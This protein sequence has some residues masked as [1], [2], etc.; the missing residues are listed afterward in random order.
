MASENK[1]VSIVIANYNCKKY[2]DMC[3]MSLAAQT[4]MNHEVII[5]DNLSE[6]DSVEYIERNYPDV[7][8]IK[9]HENMGFGAASNVGAKYAIDRGTDFILFLNFDTKADRDML[10][11]LLEYADA[12]TVVTP[13]I[14][15]DVDRTR[16][17]YA[18]G[19]LDL[20]TL[21]NE[22]TIFDG[23][24]IREA[25]EVSFISGCC[26]MVAPEILSRI[27][28]FDEDYFLY[29]EDVE[30]CVRLA[31]NNIKML[32][33]PDTALY[34]VEGGSQA[35]IGEMYSAMYYWVRNRL[36]LAEKHENFLKCSP[37][38]ILR[39][40]LEERRYF[41]YNEQYV[42]DSSVN[43]EKK[44]IGDFLQ[45]KVGKCEALCVENGKNYIMVSGKQDSWSSVGADAFL[46]IANYSDANV[47]CYLSFQVIGELGKTDIKVLCGENE[48]YSGCVPNCRYRFLISLRERERAKLRIE[49]TD[50]S[51]M[52]YPKLWRISLSQSAAEPV[53]P[54]RIAVYGTGILSQ[55][56]WD[57]LAA[58]QQNVLNNIVCYKQHEIEQYEI[59]YFVET[60]P[61]KETFHGLPV[62]S[63]GEIDFDEF[64]YLIIA[65]KNADEILQYLGEINKINNV[66]PKRIWK[67]IDFISMLS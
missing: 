47:M 16:S 9:L 3:L 8:L 57:I 10:E 64:E 14:Y 55:R 51:Q 34:H 67:G 37:M 52:F 35:R 45:G 50:S 30:L 1:K 33:V 20:T 60:A 13:W 26:M 44:A 29:W 48:L 63:A 24:A 53:G 43:Y 7:T 41:K 6:D 11:V 19:R 2:V 38:S 49:P 40:I 46:Y 15:N 39:I 62:I 32:Y 25:Q 58:Y 18:G 4:H 36:M 31:Q 59:V 23:Q 28:F 12:C 61:S 54:I 27:G 42:T 17:W 5:V 56:F 22:Q 65:I 66:D 21:W